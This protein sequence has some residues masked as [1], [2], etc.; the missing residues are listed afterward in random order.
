MME[1]SAADILSLL[2]QPCSTAAPRM[3]QTPA[4]PGDITLRLTLRHSVLSQVIT[5]YGWIP[6]SDMGQPWSRPAIVTRVTL[7]VTST[8]ATRLTSDL[9]W[10]TY[11]KVI[12]NPHS[13]L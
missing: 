6:A 5:F 4:G 13:Y 7:T 1:C 9:S 12:N 10:S 3:L 8:L 11:F 2:Q